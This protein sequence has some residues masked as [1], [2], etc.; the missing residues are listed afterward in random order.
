M[1]P[2]GASAVLQRLATSFVTALWLSTV[3]QRA[4]FKFSN[5]SYPRLLH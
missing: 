1:V 5:P 4:S 3:E 2:D